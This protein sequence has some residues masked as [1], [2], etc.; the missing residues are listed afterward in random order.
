MPS[1][2]EHL[3]LTEPTAWT[4]CELARL[5]G[6]SQES[7]TVDDLV[8]LVRDQDIRLVSLM[9]VGG[10]GYLKTLDF[11]PRDESH[12]RDILTNGERCDGANIFGAMGIPAEAS[13][14]I[15]RPHIA[16][17]FL[18]PFAEESVLVLL[19]SHCG[20][21][22]KPLMESPDTILHR[23]TE[24]L[25]R[26][27]GVELQ[28][29]GE[30]EYYL[31]KQPGDDD[32]FGL[33]DHGYH[34]SSPAVFGEDLRRSALAILA[35]MGVA[36][37]YAHSESGYIP[38][39]ENDH[40]VWEQHEI[41]LQLQPIREAADAVMLTRWVLRNLARAQGMHISYDPVV[42]AGFATNGLHFHCAL[43]VNGKSLALGN[44]FE[45]L[46]PEA[47]WLLGGLVRYSGALMAFGNRAGSS[48]LRLSQAM[49]APDSVTWGRHN[50]KALVRIPMPVTDEHGHSVSAETIEFRL[51]DGSAHP[52][53]L[54]AGIAQAMLAGKSIEGL[55]ALLTDTEAGHDAHTRSHT[56]TLPKSS[57]DVAVALREDRA[58]LEAG[59]VFPSSMIDCTIELLERQKSLNV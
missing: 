20:R 15:P 37:K 21:D 8:A 43:M 5:Q 38:A 33:D 56:V 19:C 50:R 58:V 10:D 32:E 22:G 9:H 29:L 12:L 44:T 49:N 42:R 41:E 35:E 36:L 52:H 3:E 34:A 46:P 30:V 27:T 11:A 53:L 6:K 55:D 7:W 17:A 47:K 57:D 1:S 23:A 24:R 59:G 40:R 39:S 54:L 26:E 2:G 51:P 25:Q 28:A 48:F 45:D 13:E 14:V 16:S 4:A 31:G 18:D